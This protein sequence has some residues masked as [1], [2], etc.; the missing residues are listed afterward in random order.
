MRLKFIG[1]TDFSLH[2]IIWSN[3]RIPVNF[4][5]KTAG[6]P[7]T[8]I[9]VGIDVSD[10]GTAKKATDAAERLKKAY[11]AAGASAK[12]MGTGAG[13]SQ[14]GMSAQ[15][16]AA[17]TAELVAYNRQ[18]AVSQGTGAESRD[19][20]K[21]AEGL[22]GLV[23]LYA[24]FAANVF[25]VT[26][27][28]NALSRAMDTTNMVK[29]LNQL[30]AASGVALG[31]L[32]QRLVQATDGAISLRDAMEATVKASAAGIKSQDIL[33]LG[34]VAKQASQALGVDM[35]DAINRLSRGVV[36]LEPELL[37][38]LG[39]F[40]KIDP[41]VKTYAERLNKTASELTDFER[42]QA[43]LNAV[44]EEGEKKFSAINID[45]NPYSKL[46]ATFKDLVQ[47]GLELVN[48][49]LAPLV[50]FLSQ[51]PTLLGAAIGG[52]AAL[53]IKQAIPAIGQVRAGLA[54]AAE[55]ARG[56]A[57][58]KSGDALQARK[59]LDSLLQSQIE[60][61]IEQQIKAVDDGEKKLQA[62]QKDSINRRGA[63]ARLLSKDLN[64]ITQK[65]ID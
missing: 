29:G 56:V 7:M 46:A 4:Y 62:L 47:N 18:R 60:N 8:T 49:V 39:I 51:S 52:L 61:A 26:A 24:T 23:R 3:K 16:R 54:D 53:L 37:D 9:K 11:D 21:Q 65:D 22:G 14:T 31:T 5:R 20:A 50:G 6:E 32:S 17:S 45:A 48:K 38:E 35:T 63:I 34:N 28:F 2:D 59:Q 25:A 30:G 44:L 1:L 57:S 13:G 33:R 36:K 19:F 43:F 40:T 41:A 55:R 64:D 42:R 15:A 27:A 58:T 10:N 12:N